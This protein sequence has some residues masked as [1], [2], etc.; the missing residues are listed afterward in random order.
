MRQHFN[1]REVVLFNS[2]T[3]ALA[4][5][6]AE[7][8][9]RRGGADEVI[10]PAYACPDLVSACVNA[11]ATARLV[12]S[13]P[14][15]WGYDPEALRR[16]VSDRTAAIIAV[17]LL[18]VGDAVAPI[19]EV[20][21][22]AGIPV[23]QDSA[24]CLPREPRPWPGDYVVL[25]FGRGK[26]LN[27]LRGGALVL[28]PGGALTPELDQDGVLT[29]G[30]RL[31]AAILGSRGAAL[32]FNFLSEPHVYHWVSRIPGLGLGA[33][34]YV[35][36]TAAR[37]LDPQAWNQVNAA[38][39]QYL[40]VASYSA[41]RW[42]TVVASWK[43]LGIEKL[44]A[45]DA[46][47]SDELLRLP[48]LAPDRSAR[49]RYVA[50]LNRFGLGAS[51]MYG[52]TLGEIPGVPSNIA[53]QGPFRNAQRLAQRLFTLPTHDYTT[54]NRVDLAARSITTAAV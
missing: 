6:I 1:D 4:R 31:R 24:Q 11:Q 29:R 18:G 32:A 37:R 7:C 2:G 45:A 8:R 13:P 21:A 48:L 35:P 44:R 26:P 14:D 27:L 23:I 41:S 12:D 42:N 19:L 20:A 51:V 28:P 15:L 52:T 3:A 47:P 38:F 53:A 30:E 54:A 39:R 5:A 50:T 9:Q 16:T 36:L 46:P 34:T 25:S 10:I 33:T 40:A 43:Q 49:D 17:N 22:A